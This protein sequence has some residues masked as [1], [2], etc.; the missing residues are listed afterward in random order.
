IFD[1]GESHRRKLQR[2]LDSS[3]DTPLAVHKLQEVTADME[4]L[5][6]SVEQ[7][8]GNGS[9]QP[10]IMLW[11]ERLREELD[12]LAP[13]TSMPTFHA[14]P[15]SYLIHAGV[16]TTV[17]TQGLGES[18]RSPI[19]AVAGLTTGYRRLMVNINT[20]LGFG[21][22]VLKTIAPNNMWQKGM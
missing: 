18:F 16:G 17:F 20:S 11:E 15:F 6:D 13:K 12:R 3:Q 8:T 4:R 7:S 2:T 22:V 5:I 1:I 14:G 9:L 19:N 10:Q 21:S